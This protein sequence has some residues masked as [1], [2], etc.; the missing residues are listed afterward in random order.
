MAQTNLSD[1]PEDDSCDDNDPARPSGVIDYTFDDIVDP[2]VSSLSNEYDVRLFNPLIFVKLNAI[3]YF[4]R[5]LI[6]RRSVE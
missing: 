4:F 5:R 1:S 6:W 3:F 2:R